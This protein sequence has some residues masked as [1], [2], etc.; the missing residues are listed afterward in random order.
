VASRFASRLLIAGFALG[1]LLL[2]APARMAGARKRP[3][4][5]ERILVL[6][7][8]LLGDTLMLSALLARLREKYPQAEIVMTCSPALLA[9]YAGR[10]WGVQAVPWEERNA[11]LTWALING[12]PYDLVLIPA[13]NRLSWLALAAGAKWITAFAGDRPAY[14]NWPIDEMHPFSATPV[15][16]GDMAAGLADSIPPQPFQFDSWPAPPH[17]PFSAPHGPY[18]VLHVG[19]RSPLRY[20][21]A[22]RWR[23]IADALCAQGF[24]IAI[25]CGAHETA[26]AGEIDP[27]HRHHHFAGSLDMPQLWHLLH[28]ARLVISLDTGIAHLARSASAPMVVLFGPGSAKLFGAGRFF[29]ALPERKVT[30]PNFF[31]RDQNVIF[32]RPLTWAQ[33]CAR[34]LDQCQDAKCM[35]AI[36]TI[37][38]LKAIGEL[39]QPETSTA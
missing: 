36:E 39:L 38:V 27:E 11:G 32:R 14:K 12:G 37:M 21:H 31:C 35:H 26:L 2:S 30:I 13:E 7:Q 4:A 5:A 9:L 29:S 19:A 23:E 8:L 34:G 6:H 1:R 10:P 22:A 15:A 3:A 20:W 18:C 24:E 16:W 17:R 28:G 25:T 33:H